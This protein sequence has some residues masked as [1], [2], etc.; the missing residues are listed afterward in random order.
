MSVV[1]HERYFTG[2]PREY[3]TSAGLFEREVERIFTRQWM[4]V[5]QV[6]MIREPG[7][8]FEANVAGESLLIVRD[9]E[10]AVRAYFNVCRHRGSEIC[11]AGSAGRL[12][13]IVCPYHS[14]SWDLGGRL[15][16][17]P[18]TRDG[19]AFGFADWP[20]HEARAAVFHGAI[21]VWTGETEPPP[22]GEFIGDSAD[23]AAL[24]KVDPAR[25]KLVRAE[26]YRVQANWKLLL[27]N[28]CECYHCAGTHPSLGVSCDYQG[29]F[30]NEDGTS[31]S[32]GQHFPL[33][34]G[35]KTFSMDGAWV[36]R[37]PLGA[38]DPSYL[39]T[40]EAA[41]FSAGYILVPMFSALLYFADHGVN[42][43]INP[44]SVDETEL[45]CQWFVHEDAVEATD[46]DPEALTAVFDITNREDIALAEGNQRGVRSRRY[47]PG[48]NS[49]TREPFVERALTSYLELMGG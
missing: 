29:M 43:Q 40:P 37:K 16:G 45:V 41:R 11:G 14:W 31:R 7:D 9:R 38:H 34:E 22:L 4:Y 6:G 48:P 25:Q 30:L 32:G 17:V 10:G 36:C 46:Y 26:R 39:D 3:Y 13:R 12:R 49:A 47:V 8:F 24:A 33:R 27:E 15:R 2:L 18:G 21:F 5:G 1:Q 23:Q 35:M 42:L 28:N 44:L 20:L 19:K